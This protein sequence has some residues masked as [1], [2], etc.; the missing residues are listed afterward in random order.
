MAQLHRIGLLAVAGLA[1]VATAAGGS[2]AADK[3]KAAEPAAGSPK[4][5]I[6]E[7]MKKAH[8]GKEKSL[9]AHIVSGKGTPDEK[10]QFVEYYEAMLANKPDKGDM[11]DWKTRNEAILAAAKK[12]EAGNDPKALTAL[13]SAVDCKACHDLHKES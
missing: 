2:F 7:V 4:Y 5:T 10:K 11:A 3:K 12:V 13:K 6:D 8:K 9:F 1:L